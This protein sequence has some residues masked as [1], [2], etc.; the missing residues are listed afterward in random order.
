MDYFFFL[1]CSTFPLYVSIYF[2]TQFFPLNI[3]SLL[4]TFSVSSFSNSVC[5]FSMCTFSV[6]LCLHSVC[7]FSLYFLSLSSLLGFYLFP[8]STFSSALRLLTLHSFLLSH[9]ILSCP[10]PTI[11]FTRLVFYFHM[12]HIKL[13]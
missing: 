6:Y 2:L 12:I 10:R 7:I 3:L 4:S 8:H 11:Y 5:I 9:V 13:S 1:I